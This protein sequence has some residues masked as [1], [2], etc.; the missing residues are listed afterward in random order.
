MLKVGDLLEGL[1]GVRPEGSG[2]LESCFS[3]VAIDSRLVR[4][5][6]FFIALRGEQEDGHS[7]VG[8]AFRRGAS[9][10][11]VERPPEE[12]SRPVDAAAV[13]RRGRLDGEIEIPFC[14]VVRDGLKALQRLAGYWRQRFRPRVVGVT[15]SVGK[16]ITKEAIWSVLRQGGVTLKSEGNYNN[17]IGLPLTLLRLETGHRSAVLEMGMYALGEIRGLAEIARPQVG[18]VTNVGPT[19]LE[20]LG[21]LEKIARAKAELVGA[22]PPEGMAI[23]NFD[24]HRVRTMGLKTEAAVFY[25]GLRSEAQLWASHVESRGQEGVDFRLHYDGDEIQAS[26]PMAGEHS[27]YAALAAA[28]VGL[29]EGLSWDEITRGLREA[30]G[31]VRLRTSA[32][33]RGSRVIDD[34]YNSS[35]ASAIAALNFLEGL[36]GRKVA[37]LG[38]MLELGS[39]EESGH[40]D[41]GKRAS[42]VVQQ[43]VLMGPRARIIGEEAVRCGLEEEAVFTADTNEEIIEHL[44]RVISPGDVI[45]VKGSRGMRMEQIVVALE[46]GDRW[47]TR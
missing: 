37:V 22:L 13:R 34:T 8:D 28:A 27:V 39:Y 7:F 40:R 31:Q 23:L 12:C 5:G 41:V 17:E 19:H 32:G 24:D 47:P 18:V 45:L 4:G 20:R 11:I 14:V 3:G 36:E 16:T 44:R 42:E 29:T 2:V 9:A 1:T 10:A 30:D 33:P 26:I 6:E 15:G 38:D 25:Y 21:S 35:P 43:L 46:E